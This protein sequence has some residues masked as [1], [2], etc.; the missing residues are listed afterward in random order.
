MFV[1]LSVLFLCFVCVYS[2]AW[3]SD[4]PL[5]QREFFVSVSLLHRRLKYS[6]VKSLFFCS[7]FKVLIQEWGKLDRHRM[8]KYLLF[9]RIFLAEWLHVMQCMHWEEKVRAFRCMYTPY[10][11]IYILY[12][13]ACTYNI[14]C[15]VY[16][17]G[18][19]SVFILHIYYLYACIYTYLYRY[20]YI[21]IYICTYLSSSIQ[22]YICAYIY[23][24]FVFSLRRQP[25]SF[26]AGR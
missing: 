22:L 12:V 5:V 17:L 13:C 2:A 20:I 26:Y 6:S 19:F 21:C 24:V 7:F 3:L 16:T 11:Y 1:I 15:I 4:K 23:I 14:Y 10:I 8:N 9:C 25:W 18:F